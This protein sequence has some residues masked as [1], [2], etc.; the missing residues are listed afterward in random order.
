MRFQ[1]AHDPGFHAADV[2]DNRA[3]FERGQ[4]LLRQRPHLRQRR[5]KDDEVGVGNGGQQIGRGV[6][7]RTG[8]FAILQAGFAPNESGD[9]TREPAPPGGQPDGAAEQTDADDGDFAKLHG[10]ENSRITKFDKPRNTPS[11]WKF[12]LAD[13]F[14]IICAR[15]TGRRP[16]HESGG[17][18][19]AVQTLRE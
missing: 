14:R 6:I 16:A 1:F 12:R 19:H 11:A 10:L 9:F 8:T 4:K 17:E 3:A 18:P 7:H 15:I 2:G 5:A 13:I